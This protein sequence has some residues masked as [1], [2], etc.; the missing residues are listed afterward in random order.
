MASRKRTHLWVAGYFVVAG[1]M[2]VL[3]PLFPPQSGQLAVIQGPWNA[4]P[5]E[6]VIA[7]A[8]GNILSSAGNGRVAITQSTDRE[9]IRRLYDEGAGFVVSA[10]A[11]QAC[12]RL[13]GIAG[14]TDR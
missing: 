13:I 11:A 12:I 14:K 8:G 9:F 2:V 5:A 4:V 6:A 3:A 7:R 10:I 1:V